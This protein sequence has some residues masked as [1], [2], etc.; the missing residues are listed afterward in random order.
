MFQLAHPL[1]TE[2]FSCLRE[3][4]DAVPP[5]SSREV[6]PTTKIHRSPSPASGTVTRQWLRF[7]F[8]ANCSFKALLVAYL[9][10]AHFCY[11]ICFCGCEI[12]SWWKKIWIL[13][14][15]HHRNQ[16]KHFGH[17]KSTA[18]S[19]AIKPQRGKTSAL[20]SGSQT[21]QHESM[22]FALFFFFF[23]LANNLVN[24]VSWRQHPN[25]SCWNFD[26]NRPQWWIIYKYIHVI[27]YN[28][29]K[30]DLFLFCWFHLKTQQ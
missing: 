5:R 12:L 7:H 21:E 10:H 11:K 24:K 19:E 25:L 26:K 4:Y 28:C 13:S 2:R 22:F 17:E 29:D 27:I 8:R 30:K 16:M 20:T 6:L 15:W 23:F 1:Q 3:L 14:W 9:F 18:V